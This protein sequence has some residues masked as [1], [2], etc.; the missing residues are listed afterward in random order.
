MVPR[1]SSENDLV[2]SLNLLKTE[3]GLL[4][5][6][7]LLCRVSSSSSSRGRLRA[8]RAM[9][10]RGRGS[11]QAGGSAGLAAD[12]TS[13][14]RAARGSPGPRGLVPSRGKRRWWPLSP[15]EP[16]A[17]QSGR[18]RCGC[19]G[20]REVLIARSARGCEGYRADPRQSSFGT[21][22]AAS[23][24]RDGSRSLG[25]RAELVGG[26]GSLGGDR[27]S[28][29]PR[30]LPGSLLPG[31]ALGSGTARSLPRGPLPAVPQS[32]LRLRPSESA[33]GRPA[34]REARGEGL[35]SRAGQRVATRPRAPGEPGGG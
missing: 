35:D 6:R 13:W 34:S 15:R 26:W 14:P 11:G 25:W 18:S 8:R 31:C 30:R 23:P 33:A 1:H 2:V 4:K 12:A 16:P 24:L 27:P 21:C 28:T 5:A 3:S 7:Q 17:L 29:R 32:G 22:A 20:T 9:S 10:T 19:C